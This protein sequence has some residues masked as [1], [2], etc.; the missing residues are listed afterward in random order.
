MKEGKEGGN[1][2][3]RKKWGWRKERQMEGRE[4]GKKERR[5]SQN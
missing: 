5:N 1:K 4:E 3:G 2:E